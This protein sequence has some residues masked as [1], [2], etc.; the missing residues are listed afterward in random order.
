MID[1]KGIID[2]LRDEDIIHLMEHFGVR[3]YKNTENAII[4]PTICH[5]S[6]I[7]E[8]SLKLYYYKDTHLFY[9]YTECGGQSIFKLIEHIYQ[10]RG[11]E[12]DWYKDVFLPV[13]DCSNFRELK[14]SESYHQLRDNYRKKNREINLPE[15]NKGVLDV[16]FKIYPEQWIEEGISKET[17]EKFGICFSFSQNKIIIPHYDAENRLV[18]I[19][20]RAL[21][22]WE[23]ENLGKYMPVQIEKKWYAHKLSLNLY[24]LNE[25]KENIKK[26]GTVF[27][28]ESEKSVLKMEDFDCINCAVAVCGSTLNKFQINLL[29][30]ECHPRNFVICFDKEEKAGEDKYFSKLYK[31]CKKYSL[32]GNF[33]FIYDTENLLDMK[34]SPVD[35]GEDIFNKLLSRRVIVNAD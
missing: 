25:T 29:V 5:N 19:R 8:A 28:F 17:M 10:A 30:K 7:E 18:G 24:G 23:V 9:C 2:N 11:Q 1:Y 6:N 33:S 3:N 21:D 31:M 27:I 15:F 32:Y 22:E 12:Y 16:F 4:F 14:N 20:G 34:D 13:L 26:T 35:K